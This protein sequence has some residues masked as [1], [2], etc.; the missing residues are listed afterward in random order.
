MFPARC[1]RRRTAREPAWLQVERAAQ[2]EDPPTGGTRR[3][4]PS[5]RAAVIR[6]PF[7][8]NCL[9]P[10][11]AGVHCAL[12]PGVP[13]FGYFASINDRFLGGLFAWGVGEMFHGVKGVQDF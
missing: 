3:G 13:L 12:P 6:H 11:P 2:R 9:L 4:G 5:G 8:P 10:C 1:P 7:V